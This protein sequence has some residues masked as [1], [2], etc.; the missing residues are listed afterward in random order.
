VS[1]Y[2]YYD[3]RALDRPQLAHLAS[4]V[5]GRTPHRAVVPP[6]GRAFGR[7]GNRQA[8]NRGASRHNGFDD[9]T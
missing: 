7:P 3:F 2:Q 5:A 4:S 6:G 1:E 9:R 8:L